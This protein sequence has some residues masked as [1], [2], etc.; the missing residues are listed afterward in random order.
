MLVLMLLE[1]DEMHLSQ[2]VVIICIIIIIF[3]SAVSI[4]SR[5]E[6]VLKVRFNCCLR[7]Q[8]SAARKHP[9]NYP[10]KFHVRS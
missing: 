7:A 4:I 1:E 8:K 9:R 5:M 10:A 6:N 2:L 3:L